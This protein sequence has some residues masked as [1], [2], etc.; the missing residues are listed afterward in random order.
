[1]EGRGQ[2]AVKVRAVASLVLRP[3]LDQTHRLLSRGPVRLLVRR[4]WEDALPLE[5]LLAGA[6]LD[7]WGGAVPHNLTGRGPVQVLATPR[8]EIVAKSLRRGGLAGGLLRDTFFRARRPLREAEAAELLAQRGVRTPA[9]V[10]ARITRRAAGLRLETATARVAGR[11]LIEALAGGVPIAA[12]AT[13]LGRT[14]RAAHE[15]G[16]RHRDLQA[17]NLL[18]PAGFPG[19][20]GLEDPEP[21]VIL[22]L[23]RCWLGAEALDPGERRAAVVRLGRSL[24]K[25]GI[26]PGGVVPARAPRTALWGCRRFVRAYGAS[27]GRFLTDLA[28]ALASQV[29]WHRWFWTA[30]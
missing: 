19:P 12:L 26:L 22:D 8:G 14:L 7:Q 16:L 17:R 21:L 3:P 25:Q 30:R 29:R 4:D 9:V 1:V 27:E 20:G 5:A 11:D 10:V 24:V 28:S 13:A 15:A 23:D 18:V 2:P 6:A